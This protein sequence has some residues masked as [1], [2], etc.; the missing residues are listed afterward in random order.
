MKQRR[1]VA[2]IAGACLIA[3]L[4]A[5]TL[6]L[7]HIDQLRPQ[8]TLE[9]VLY[10]NSPKV[11]KRLSLG[12]NGLLADIYWTRAVQYFGFRHHSGAESFNLLAPLLEITTNL[13]PHLTAAYQFGASFLAPRP[14]DGAGQPERAIQLMEFGIQN[15]PNDWKLYY[16]LGFIY[17]MNLKDYPKAADAFARG[18]K[19]PNAHPFLRLLAAQM[20]EHAG[21]YETARMMWS[22]TYQNS[23][24]KQIRQNAIEHLRGLRVDEDIT[25]LQKLVTRFGERTGRLPSSI[26]ELAATE[27]LRGLPADP[28]GQPYK[29]TP[30]GRIELSDPDYFPFATKGFPPGYK[31]PQNFHYDKP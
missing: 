30:Q 24:D 13:D 23:Q 19:V 8:A 27:G 17:Y 14:P 6:V 2:M 10:L 7:H 28:L 4:A 29:L 11:L 20:A 3:S 21:E 1:Q 31:P 26:S 22:A 16:D 5:S 15:N 12:Y 18:S 9:D 25:E